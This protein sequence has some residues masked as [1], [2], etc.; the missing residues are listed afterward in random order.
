MRRNSR[1]FFKYFG[2]ALLLVLMTV[3]QATPKLLPE[4]MGSKPFLLLALALA[5]NAREEF[6]PSIVFAS[7]C[8]VFADLNAGGCV[9]YFAVTLTLSCAA[10]HYITRTY[11]NN[12]FFTFIV[13][14]AAA[15]A[16]VPGLYFVIFRIASGEGTGGMF[17]SRYLPRMALTLLSAVP[18]YFA[19]AFLHNTLTASR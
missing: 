7:L 5:V 11:L 8:G 15:V 13:T 9:G 16:A 10:V 6:I 4:P 14:S 19:A 17:V 1:S 3:L 2:F 12:T 18:L